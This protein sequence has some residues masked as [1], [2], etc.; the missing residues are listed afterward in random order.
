M[1]PVLLLWAFPAFI[2]VGGAGYYLMAIAQIMGAALAL[3]I[4]TEMPPDRRRK[5]TVIE[6][7]KTERPGGHVR[8]R[9]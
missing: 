5:F 7:G 8:R 2:V 1:M 6:G 3:A 4:P 9:R